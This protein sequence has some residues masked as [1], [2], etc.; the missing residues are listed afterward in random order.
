MSDERR[1]FDKEAAAWDENPGRVRL[2]GEVA[3]T[4]LREVTLNA[5][6]DVL[7]FGCGTGLISLRLAPLVR[8]VTGV[9]SSQGMLDVLAAKVM[10]QKLSNVRTL[11]LDIEKGDTLP[12]VYDLVVSS[13]TLH[14]IR[15]IGA[16]LRQFRRVVSPSGRL[17]L[18]DLDLDDGQF[19][20]DNQGVLHFGFDRAELCTAFVNAGFEQV[21]HVT[22]A[23]MV[24]P[25]RDGG[26]R[27]FTIFLMTGLVPAAST[28]A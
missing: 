11:R 10:K 14:H 21:H 2:A 9:D 16:L 19:H 17:C 24:K 27:R 28:V 22:A 23:E 12:G 18:A 7:D 20:S 6:M 15:D 8:S 25:T 1:D 3:D 13:M 4:I 26:M 5:G